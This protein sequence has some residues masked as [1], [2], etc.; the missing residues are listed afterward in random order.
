MAEAADRVAKVA[1]GVAEVAD[2]VAEVADGVAEVAD[3]VAKVA[4][5]VAEVA[6][7]PSNG[8][9]NRS[10]EQPCSVQPEKREKTKRPDS[11]S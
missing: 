7:C 4:D 5:G 11:L 3:G 2:R 1:D 10:E 8:R 6:G 9:W